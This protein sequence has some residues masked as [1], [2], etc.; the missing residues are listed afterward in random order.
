MRAIFTGTSASTCPGLASTADQ[1]RRTG[2]SHRERVLLGL[3]LYHRHQYKIKD[4]AVLRL[5]SARERAWARLL[6]TCANLAHHLT[7]GLP[8]TLNRTALRVD[9]KALSLELAGPAAPLAG[10]AVDLRGAFGFTQAC[11]VGEFN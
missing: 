9:K 10:E 6:G 3:A 5:V 1:A 11:Y 4:E 7:G 2:I 8:G